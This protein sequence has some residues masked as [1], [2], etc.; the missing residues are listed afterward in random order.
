MLN[1]LSR[2]FFCDKR[3]TVSWVTAHHS[4]RYH[5]KPR[6]RLSFPV[7]HFRENFSKTHNRSRTEQR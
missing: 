6:F 2:F 7:I 1:H 5:E 4:Q 3:R